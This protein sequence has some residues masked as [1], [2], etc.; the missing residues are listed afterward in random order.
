M[1]KWVPKKGKSGLIRGVSTEG[2][3]V[4]VR[5]HGLGSPSSKEG[6][7]R[8]NLICAAPELYFALEDCVALLEVIKEHW[9]DYDQVFSTGVSDAKA[10]I[11]KAEGRS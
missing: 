9:I 1:V 8:A 3:E 6:Q 2:G 10:V 5:W 7:K 11:A 4:V